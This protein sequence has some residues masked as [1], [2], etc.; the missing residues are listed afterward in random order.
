MKRTILK[1]YIVQINGVTYKP[2]DLRNEESGIPLLRANNIFDGA[3]S[4]DDLV[5]IDKA[6]INPRQYLQKGDIIICSSSG[7]KNLVGKAAAYF[8]NHDLCSVGAFCKILRPTDKR[9][10]AYLS[11]FFQSKT[12]RNEISK[13]SH[14]A[15][16]NNI[17][18]GDIDTISLIIYDEKTNENISNELNT[19]IQTI[20]QKRNQVNALD[21]LVKSR[22]L[23]LP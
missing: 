19:L 22:F 15:N 20:Q 8:G 23:L 17:K 7:S 3:L 16:I 18:G 1:D 13:K 12:Y 21:S 11:L 9:L 6:K 10:Q 2:S 5:Y 14:G 4:F